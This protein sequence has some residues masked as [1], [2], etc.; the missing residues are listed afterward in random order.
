MILPRKKLLSLMLASSLF[1][2]SFSGTVSFAAEAADPGTAVTLI[3]LMPSVPAQQGRFVTTSKGVMFRLKSGGYLKNCWARI[4]GQIYRF[5]K[6][7]Y[8]KT[9]W[10][11]WQGKKYYLR[12]NGALGSN[13]WVRSGSQKMYVQEDGTRATGFVQYK[14]YTYYFNSYGYM[15]RGFRNIDGK[16]YF[17][18]KNGTMATGWRYFPQKTYYFTSDGSAA[19]GWKK[20]GGSWYYFSSK[21]VMAANR[22]VDGN[23]LGEDG[24]KATSLSPEGT[25]EETRYRIFCG[26]SRTK[27][28][29]NAVASSENGYVAKYG[30]GYNWFSNEGVAELK[31]LL[32]MHPQ[33]DVVLNFGVNDLY[34]ISRYIQLYQQ[35]M[36]AYPQARFYVMSVNPVEDDKYPVLAQH[37]K[38]TKLVKIFNSR[39]KAAFPYR[40]IDAYNYLTASG[41]ETLDGCHYTDVTYLKIYQYVLN[42]LQ[43]KSSNP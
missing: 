1:S 41:Y 12:K 33:A 42:E 8:R 30:Q 15:V 2:A 7:G 5:D 26:D 20:I 29:S 14:K 27:Q 23:Y 38:S 11:S 21:G 9:G 31:K 3:Q 4:N 24:K 22:W 36:T 34:N 16:L 25:A 32:R 18:H 40:Y 43:K 17:F 19:T 13:L 37:K 6:N 35:L 28:L 10:F 39:M